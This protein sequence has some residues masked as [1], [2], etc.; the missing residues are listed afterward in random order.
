MMWLDLEG[1]DDR[2]LQIKETLKKNPNFDT[3]FKKYEIASKMRQWSSE[4]KKTTIESLKE[5]ANKSYSQMS[6]EEREAIADSK[7]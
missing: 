5:E 6:E 3:V 7:F 2:D 4:I 1:E